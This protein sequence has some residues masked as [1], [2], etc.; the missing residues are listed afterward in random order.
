M[1][2]A[3]IVLECE[4]YSVSLFSS[5]LKQKGH[6]AD[7]VFDP[8]LFGSHE[9]SSSRLKKL[10]D[11]RK[12]N[13]EK[14]KR[15]KP[16]LIGFSV[17]TSDYRWA[18]EMATMIKKEVDIPIIIGGIHCILVPEEV[19]KEDCIDIVCVGEGEGALLELVESMKSGEI[20]QSIK[21]LW[22]KTKD[23]KIIR[24]EVRPLIQDLDSLPFLD[25]DIIFDQKPIFRW[26]YSISTGRGCPY[27]CSFCVS[28]VLNRYYAERKL[29]R[30]VRQRSVKNV[31]DE[32]V[33]AREKYKFKIVTFTD[34]VF[35]ININWLKE[36]VK[37]YKEKVKI[38]FFCTANPGTI[39]DEELRLLKEANCSMIG[40]GVQSACEQTR[41]NTLCR[42]G[43]NERIKQVA[44]LCH[45]LKIT[46]HFDHIFN[47]P[48]EGIEEQAQALSF[49]NETRPDLVN[50]FW[51]TYFPKIKILDTA[52]EK[53]ILTAEMVERINRGETSVSMF[54]GIGCKYSFGEK[55][56]YDTFAFLFVVLP[57]MPRW[58]CKHII[59][60]G[61]YKKKMSVPFLIRL[62]I[63]DL[64]R[65][66][67]RRFSEIFFPIELFIVN[68][69]D[70]TKIKFF[71]HFRLRK[72]RLPG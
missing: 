71:D 16:D 42:R 61:W 11:I 14:I 40:F 20:D 23:K 31:I 1:K 7:M 24:N 36:F 50:T 58:L 52:L 29:G 15:I 43:T 34:D 17:Y 44:K 30:F 67:I 72:N 70:N 60:K 18:L 12:N 5:L 39:K 53:G 57:F 22:F 37:E 8:R 35:T 56:V 49:Y 4:N 28:E 64:A 41:V 2:V 26:G 63:K 33:W 48:G 59:K 10:F 27:R 69:I 21:N 55:E 13:I 46:F 68:I 65:I 45:E 19:I 51:M 66:R 3:F 6:E 38:P 25:R 32:L 47:L 9:I 54:I 62:A